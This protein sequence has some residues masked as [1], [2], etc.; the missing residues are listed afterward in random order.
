MAKGHHSCILS[1]LVSI[2]P[3]IIHVM[4]RCITSRRKWIGYVDDFIARL[5]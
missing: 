1:K 2:K 4:R 3:I 5:G